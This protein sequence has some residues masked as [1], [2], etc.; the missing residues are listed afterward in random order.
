M[1][2]VECKYCGSINT[3]RKGFRK[4][5]STGERIAQRYYCND[6]ERRFTLQDDSHTRE[7]KVL[8]LDIETAP[9]TVFVW[10]LYK[11]RISHDN[12]ISDWFLLSWS[13]KWLFHPDIMSDVLTP[14]EAK[15]KDDSR[16]AKSIYALMDKADIIIAHNGKRFDDRKLKARFI[17]HGLN[18]PSPYQ[19]IDTLHHSRANFAFSSHKQDYLTK[20]LDL[21]NK[22]DTD[23]ELWIRCFNGEKEAL[24]EM[25]EY[26]RHDVGG[27][28]ELYLTLRPWMKSHPNM[29]LYVEAD[30]KVCANCGSSQLTLMSRKYY[31][32]PMGKYRVH[33]CQCGAIVRERLSGLSQEERNKLTVSIAR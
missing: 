21:P 11:Q 19:V 4:S 9:M 5:E 33:R 7:P 1:S 27:L 22:L 15:A 29:G 28:E 10:G 16:I 30:K 23:F 14:K 13:A 25:V 6:C 2:F 32:T 12:I 3:K 18:P 24:E 8:I 17:A 31:V 26:N 20:F